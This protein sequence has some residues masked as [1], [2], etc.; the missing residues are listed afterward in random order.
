M[1]DTVVVSVSQVVAYNLRRIRQALG[2]NQEQ[3]TERLA[4]FLGV[5]WSKA[6]YSAAERSYDGK[7][8]R[9][10]TAAEVAAFALAFGVPAAYFFLPPKPEDRTADSVLIGKE[11]LP[12]AALNGIRIGGRNRFNMQPRLE[13]LPPEERAEDGAYLM[14]A[15]AP[16]SWRRVAADGTVSVH[17]PATGEWHDTEG[18]SS[19]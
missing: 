2:L 19:S 9:Q 10:F 14:S 5:R 7:R 3:A 15:R 16:G 1:P 8:V 4:P 6:V 18:E 13:E 17:D 11:I 12:W